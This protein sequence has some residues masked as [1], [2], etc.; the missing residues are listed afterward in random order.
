MWQAILAPVALSM[1]TVQPPGDRTE[2]L[3]RRARSRLYRLL[4]QAAQLRLTVVPL[5]YLRERVALQHGYSEPAA[6]FLAQAL[7]SALLVASGLKD[8]EKVKILVESHGPGQGWLAEAT[9]SG[10]A[11]GYLFQPDIPPEA[12]GH[13]QTWF[14]EGTFTVTRFM[15]EMSFSPVSS[16]I[17]GRMGAPAADLEHFLWLSDQIP[18]HVGYGEEWVWLLQALPGCPP[19][20]I[21]EACHVL[22]AMDWSQQ[23]N[24]AGPP[25]LK[26]L[27]SQGYRELDSTRVDFFCP[28][29]RQRF[30]AYLRALPPEER[31]DIL[32]NGPFPVEVRCHYCSSLYSFSREELDALFSDVSPPEP[33]E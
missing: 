16:T 28:C 7:A 32:K 3:K 21:E 33:G 17:R 18:S 8:Q 30:A 10:E 26:A 15:E 29:Q 24:D 27:H 22:E 5:F 1:N 31:A 2:L 6:A 11:R 4:D 23:P 19:Q 25:I 12:I 13:W 20:R 14:G 9:C